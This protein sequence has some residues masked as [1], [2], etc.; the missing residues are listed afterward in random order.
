MLRYDLIE[1]EKRIILLVLKTGGK[2]GI[3]FA[4]IERT[5]SWST[6]MLPSISNQPFSLRLMLPF[7]MLLVLF[8]FM[9]SDIPSGHSHII[10]S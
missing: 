7:Q 2:N 4:R 8:V 10:V 9:L 6:F 5:F 1:W 3:V